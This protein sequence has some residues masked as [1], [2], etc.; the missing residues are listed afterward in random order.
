MHL[1]RCCRLKPH[2]WSLYMG[3]SHKIWIKCEMRSLPRVL[4]CGLAF[5]VFASMAQHTASHD[6]CL[7]PAVPGCHPCW[8]IYDC[9]GLPLFLAAE[10]KA[11]SVLACLTGETSTFFFSKADIGVWLAGW[12]PLPFSHI[13]M[14]PC[15]TGM[16]LLGRRVCVCVCE[17]WLTLLAAERVPMLMRSSEK[18]LRG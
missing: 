6:L 11:A 1:N 16:H 10:E 7:A 5:P 13:S 2:D 15:H 9:L 8:A 14:P 12:L 3:G 4:C 18:T 17:G